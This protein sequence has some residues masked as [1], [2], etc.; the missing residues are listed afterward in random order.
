VA[1]EIRDKLHQY[2][3][4]TFLPGEPA[5]SLESQTPLISSGIIDSLAVL[6]MVTYIEKAFAVRLEQEDLGRERLDT[7]ELIEAVI[8]E[9]RAS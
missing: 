4:S 1:S 8:L 7:I 3:L 6:D 2:V 5:E 9:R